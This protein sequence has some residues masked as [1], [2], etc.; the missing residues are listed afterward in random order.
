[1]NKRTGLLARLTVD[2]QRLLTLPPMLAAIIVVLMMLQPCVSPDP[3]RTDCSLRMS[4]GVVGLLYI[5]LL[6]YGMLPL[7]QR[8]PWVHW[9]IVLLNGAGT[10]FLPIVVDDEWAYPVSFIAII[11]MVIVSALLTG[12]GPTYLLI[13]TNT[14][15]SYIWLGASLGVDWLNWVGFASAPVMAVV[16]TETIMR[17]RTVINKQL[18]RLET[19]NSIAH[20]IAGSIEPEQ[21]VSIINTAIRDHLVADSY[22]IGLLRD[23]KLRLDVFY[24]GGEFFPPI[25]LPLDGSLSGWVITHRQS[26]MMSDVPNESKNLGIPVQLVG[27]S[28]Q[29]LSWMGTPMEVGGNIL[30]I[31]AMAS[32]KK[33]AFDRADLELL[34]SVAQ[35][36]ALV[37]DNA[38]HHAEVE[39]QSHRDSLTQVY[40]HGYF[41]TLL[42]EFVAYAKTNN[43]PISLIMLDIDYFKRYNDNYGHLVGDKV[44]IQVVET[45]RQNIRSTDMIGRWGGEEFAI[46]LLEAQGPQVYQVAER[47]RQT[48]SIIR[49][50]NQEEQ[51]IPAPTVS[52]GIAVCPYEVDDVQAL[53]HLADQRLYVA[54]G[55]GRNQVEPEECH[56][57][58]LIVPE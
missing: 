1:M 13:S 22:F 25:E 30:G 47:I 23:G 44:L 37:I 54:K 46:M 35:Q 17:L 24:D 19:I 36:S 27:K 32:Y 14:A 49:L 7:A 16:V 20:R 33:D 15:L 45:I 29:S 11:S 51:V 55:R 52:Q 40:N 28:Q 9:I 2:E 42:N 18:G 5:L 58:R 3:E 10:A 6:F 50:T 56:W 31:I 12:R 41:L 53:V 26:L 43:T 48:L 8:Y 38:Y 21:V 4:F 57:S 39:D 34:E